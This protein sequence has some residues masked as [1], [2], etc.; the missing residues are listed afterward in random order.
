MTYAPN[1][2]EVAGSQ[3]VVDDD[4]DTKVVNTAV[5]HAVVAPGVVEKVGGVLVVTPD[6]VQSRAIQVVPP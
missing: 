4:V 6:V 3:F 5:P 1:K 2:Y